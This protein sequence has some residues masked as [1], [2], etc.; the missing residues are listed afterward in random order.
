MF[1]SFHRKRRRDAVVSCSSPGLTAVCVPVLTR[2]SLL[3]M[4]SVLRVFASSGGRRSAVLATGAGC[5][6]VLSL[7]LCPS[8]LAAP[9][10][11]EATKAPSPEPAAPVPPASDSHA[12]TLEPYSGTP[13]PNLLRS[14]DLVGV[15]L[16]TKYGF[17]SVYAYALWVDAAKYR[18]R[19][20]K[21]VY[22]E[23]IHGPDRKVSKKEEERKT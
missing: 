10:S 22:D 1:H 2:F 20:E 8:L 23:L 6:A 21:Q 19:P 4:R 9:S 7:S 17:F 13:F 18:T 12:V 15:G 5:G 16:R 3:Q 11:P 14:L